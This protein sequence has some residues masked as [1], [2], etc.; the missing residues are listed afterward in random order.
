MSNCY[1]IDFSGGDIDFNIMTKSLDVE[2]NVAATIQ[3]AVVTIKTAFGS[4]RFYTDFGCELGGLIGEPL[5]TKG[6]LSNI[7]TKALLK[8]SR[9]KRAE[10][11]DYEFN[12]SSRVLKLKILV[13]LGEYNTTEE[14]ITEVSE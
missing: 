13:Q 10:V 11:T 2:R 12:P 14:I 8:D 3:D 6:E 9:F 4:N 5:V 1:K 7:I